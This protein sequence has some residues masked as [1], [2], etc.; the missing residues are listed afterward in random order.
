[1]RLFANELTTHK[2][3]RIIKANRRFVASLVFYAGLMA[4]ALFFLGK[5]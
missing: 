4:A 3:D 5:Y 1:M 2:E